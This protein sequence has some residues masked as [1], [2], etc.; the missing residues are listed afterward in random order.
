MALTKCKKCGANVE[1]EEGSSVPEYMATYGDM[2]TLLLCFFVLL[3]S[4]ATFDKVKLNIVLSSFRG[5]LG[6]LEQGPSIQKSKLLSMGVGTQQLSKG[7]PIMATGREAEKGRKEKQS[8]QARAA[9]VMGEEMK[10]GLVK[11]RHDE[12]GEIVQLTDKTLFAPGE[13][14]L[15]PSARPILDK[16]AILLESIP[17]EIVVEGH[18]DNRPI[19]TKEIPSNWY[20][21]AMRATNVLDYLEAKEDIGSKRLSVAAYGEHKPI[22]PNDSLVNRAINRRVDIVIRREEVGHEDPLMD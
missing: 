3:V 9:M 4:M 19:H 13:F 16:L 11:F 5:A 14:Q 17:N 1:Y 20:L 12:R 18:T 15:K 22:V 2:V 21:S 7:I 10:R 8:L 6:V